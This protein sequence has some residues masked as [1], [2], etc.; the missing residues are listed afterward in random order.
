MV[1]NTWKIFKIIPLTGPLFNGYVVVKYIID[2]P[3]E[4]QNKPNLINKGK[5]ITP[6]RVHSTQQK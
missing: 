1:Y 4:K 3:A 5:L 6:T 2:P